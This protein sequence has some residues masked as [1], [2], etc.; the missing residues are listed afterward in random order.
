MVQDIR[1][2][3]II[4][5]ASIFIHPRSFSLDYNLM[6][7]KAVMNMSP[8]LGR[9]CKFEMNFSAPCHKEA[10]A[11]NRISMSGLHQGFQWLHS[12]S[13]KR[14]SEGI[15]PESVG[16]VC[17]SHVVGQG[18]DLVLEMHEG[19][20]R[21]PIKG[22]LHDMLTFQPRYDMWEFADSTQGF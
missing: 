14:T 18:F 1:W 10:Y 8:S 20:G 13:S 6:H 15:G 7:H 9:M 5:H 12:V 21:M 4:E 16:G 22:H 3:E 2:Q 11:A 17:G 19:A